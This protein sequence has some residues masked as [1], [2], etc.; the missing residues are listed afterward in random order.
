MDQK[1]ILQQLRHTR[2]NVCSASLFKQSGRHLDSIGAAFQGT[3]LISGNRFRITCCFWMDTVQVTCKCD[4]WNGDCSLDV[5]GPLTSKF[6]FELQLGRAVAA[7]FRCGMDQRLQV[8]LTDAAR[9][10]REPR[11]RLSVAIFEPAVSKHCPHAVAIW[12][13][14]PL[15][16]RG[17]ARRARWLLARFHKLH[18]TKTTISQW[19]KDQ[20]LTTIGHDPAASWRLKVLGARF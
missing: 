5:H 19:L 2:D 10:W 4:M 20:Y 8:Y 13:R 15:I 14:T 12:K 9:Q 11:L 18:T 17:F 6:V 7:F 3:D 16:S 1:F